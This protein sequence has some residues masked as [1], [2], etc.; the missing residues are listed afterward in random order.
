M[1]VSE[2]ATDVVLAGRQ[3]RRTIGNY[4]NWRDANGVLAPTDLALEPIASPP[5]GWV[6]Q[7]KALHAVQRGPLQIYLGD[8]SDAVNTALVAIR[9]S[10]RPNIGLAFKPLGVNTV[11]MTTYPAQQAVGWTGLWAKSNLFYSAARGRLDKQI[12]LIGPGHPA[13]FRFAYK[14]WP[15]MT[16]AI[17]DGGVELRD[18]LGVLALRMPAPYGW[19]SST[20]ALTPD[21]TQRIRVTLTAGAPVTYEGVQV[22]TFWLTPNATDLTGATYPVYL[23]PTATVSTGIEDTFLFA[24]ASSNWGGYSSPYYAPT[25]FP[26]YRFPAASIPAGTISALRF[27]GRTPHTGNTLKAYFVKDADTWV[28]GTGTGS[29]Q[30]G[31]CCATHCKYN[32]QT[33]ISGNFSSSDYDADAAPPTLVTSTGAYENW[34]LKASWAIAWRDAARANNGFVVIETAGGTGYFYGVGSAY[35]PYFEIDYV[36]GASMPLL[37]QYLSRRR[38]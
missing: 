34:A 24:G 26:L 15:G 10:D 9:R 7:F 31:S 12:R 17:V 21:G 22:P 28:E 37:A 38:R 23:D 11:P 8:S 27:F 13:A 19:D 20:T 36:A 30:N 5:P 33:W 3:M 1:I 16:A 25:Y 18:S 6:G 35:P 29:A 32:T 4:L 2:H 14:L